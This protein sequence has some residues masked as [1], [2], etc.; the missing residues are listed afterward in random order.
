MSVHFS[1]LYHVF[2][3]QKQMTYNTTMAGKSKNMSQIK[4]LLLLKKNGVSN[5]KAAEIIG[6]NKETVNNY[7]NKVNA[8]SLSIDE[9]LRL[10]DPVLEHRLKGGNPAYS[11]RRFETFKHLL[12]YLQEE[13]K[14]KHVTLK[15]LW[16]EYRNEHPDNHYSLTQ[17]RYH[18]NQNT[19]AGKESPST[20][21]AD[22]RTGG[23]K[24]FLDFAGDTM[25]YVD[26]ETGEPVP[27]QVFVA[28]LP[29][30][31]YGYILFVRSQ[32]TEDFVYAVI[33]CLKHLGGVPKM[34]V[35]DNLKS[36]VVKTDR[37]EPSLNRV[38]EDMANHYGTVVVPARPAHPKDKTNVE[39]TVRLV[40]MRVFAELRNETFHSL[41]ELNRAASLKMKAHNQKRMQKHP[42]T[43]EERFLAIDKHNLMPLPERDFEIV[44]YTDL[45]VSGNCCVYL[46]RDQHYYTVPY[47]HISKTAH[48]AYTRTMV[49]IYVEGELVA[50]HIRDYSKGKYTIVKEHLA[51]SSQEYRGLSARSYI[52][53]AERASD[54]LGAVVS[55]I[56]YSSSMPPETHYRTCDGLLN[57]QRSSDP[58]IFHKACE[59][60]LRLDRCNYRFIRSL[61]ESKCAGIEQPSSSFAPPEH[62]NIRG[63]AQFK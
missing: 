23:E 60:A 32:C 7:M 58:D 55:R 8:D 44:S 17:L 53:R 25:G 31:D 41:E 49:K 4:Q 11:D 39:G 59:T 42:Y 9:L 40:Y 14:R 19:E 29:A 35:P 43:R 45:K 5:R 30:S 18:Y 51:S 10:D 15:L 28:T 33:Q 13:M 3:M 6:I 34:L 16:E 57:L 36:A 46:G 38:M 2:C 50:T 52:E 62:G 26:R 61:V 21:L 12:P 1:T 56:F 47:R 24:L 63:K 48:V 20:I 37:Y 27:C 22:M 54:I